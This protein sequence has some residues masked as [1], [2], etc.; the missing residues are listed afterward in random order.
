MKKYRYLIITLFSCLINAQV[1]I[2]KESISNSSA[3][4]EFAEGSRGLV[5]PWVDSTNPNTSAVDG[6]LIFDTSDFKVKYRSINKW[7]DISVDQ[8]VQ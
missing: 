4:L 5:L 7:L 2:G 1:A 6:T 3:S 8:M